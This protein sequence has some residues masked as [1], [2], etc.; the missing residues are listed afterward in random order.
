MIFGVLFWEIRHLQE[1]QP[2]SN[3]NKVAKPSVSTI[4]K[5]V[6]K[7]G[8][9]QGS[10]APDFELENVD[11]KKMGLSD[12][13]GKKVIINF[14]STWCPPCKAEMPYIE[15]FYEKNKDKNVV[16][17]AVN[18]AN[19]EKNKNNIQ[20]F[21]KEHNITFPVLLD[22]NG[23]VANLYQNITIPTTFIIDTTGRVDQKIVGPMQKGSL[24][25][26]ISK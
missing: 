15:N 6:A 3:E 23:N 13:K 7:M 1:D 14:W 2:V 16:V 20:Q 5:D 8:I 4:E 12:Y 18:L 9:Q 11:G 19:L 26:L 25:T 24:E 10:I 22:Y 17:L 21:I